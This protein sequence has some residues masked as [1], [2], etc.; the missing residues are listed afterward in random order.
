MSIQRRLLIFFLIVVLIPMV[1]TALLTT[2]VLTTALEQKA[3]KDLEV[4]LKWAWSVVRQR[5]DTLTRAARQAVAVGLVQLTTGDPQARE[6][7][8]EALLQ[9]KRT[10]R[11]SFVAL[12][13]PGGVVLG[14]AGSRQ[15][16]DTY[17]ALTVLE[18]AWAGEVTS[19]LEF[20]PAA[21]VE[22]EGLR[23]QAQVALAT[24]TK[25][26]RE[27]LALVAAVPV[28]DGGG[29][30]R[31]VLLVGELLN[32]QTVIP[33][34]V[35]E[36]TGHVLSIWLRDISIATNA[37]RPDGS[38]AVGEKLRQAIFAPG[39]EEGYQEVVLAGEPQKA[40]RS[41]IRNSA[42]Q[43]IGAL[44]VGIPLAQID[45]PRRRA[46]TIILLASAGGSAIA[47][48]IASYLARRIS[49]PLGE[50][51]AVTRQVAQGDLSAEVPVV[52]S[53]EIG[54]LARSF[55]RMIH[56][57]AQAQEQLVR[58]QRLAAIGQLAGS[59]SH[60]L[61][62]PLSVLRSSAYYLRSRLGT[63]DEKVHKHLNII[64]QE[65]VNSDKIITDLLDFS[66]TKPPTLQRTFLNYIVEESLERVE[67]PESVKLVLQ[68]GEGLPPLRA[69][70]FQLEQVVV[71]LLT[72]AIQAMPQGGVL[73]VRTGRQDDALTLETS[74]TGCGIEP[75]NLSRIFEPLFTTKSRGIGL[76]LAIS[77]TLVEN[78]G[79]TITVDS[80][81][82]QGT[83]FTITLPREPGRAQAQAPPQADRADT[84]T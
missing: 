15:A 3:R 19:G 1:D 82:G 62:N 70:T 54:Q 47:V 21:L 58:S 50:M 38:R 13:G 84:S 57:L 81:P 11:L 28:T 29:Q 66:R 48:I 71:N 72:N 34:L 7:A 16:G 44:Q 20:I 23:Q 26:F 2:R 73:T 75:E 61:R 65:I 52:G 83:T 41:N 79:G 24:P 22:R 8:R 17:P 35:G 76:G 27:A 60:E 64:E 68:L 67:V 9:L 56:D 77:K 39:S 5:I 43:I 53:D 55:N 80:V 6:R 46:L 32:N 45:E 37:R 10:Q 78:H 12:L 25:V 31:A 69:D 40:I 30:V 49:R 18:G 36:P 14:R 4:D 74:D 33:D 42:N 51:V 63:S 59:M